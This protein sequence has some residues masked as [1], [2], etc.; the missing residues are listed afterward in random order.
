LLLAYFMH[1]WKTGS[2]PTVLT[3]CVIL[4]HRQHRMD[5]PQ[6][7]YQYSGGTLAQAALPQR[8]AGGSSITPP[9]NKVEVV[10][11]LTT[12]ATVRLIDQSGTTT[13]GAS[14][15]VPAQSLQRYTKNLVAGI[16][17]RA[18]IWR[19]GVKVTEIQSTRTVDANPYRR[20][21]TYWQFSNLYDTTYQ[22]RIPG[23]NPPYPNLNP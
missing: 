10:V 7:A 18:E 12:P 22:K 19:G 17:P 8:G 23:P 2:Y 16:A 4:S 14:D 1:R 13:F 11:F 3:D 21:W 9:Q 15:T 5:L 6:S 20:D